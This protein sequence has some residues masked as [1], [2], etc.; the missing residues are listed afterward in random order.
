M[1]SQ[2]PDI[3]VE[4]LQKKNAH[5]PKR[6]EQTEGTKSKRTRDADETFILSTEAS[7]GTDLEKDQRA[8]HSYLAN[9]H[10]LQT[11]PP[12]TNTACQA[13]EK[14]LTD[15]CA[16]LGAE[17]TQLKEKVDYLSFRQ[18]SFRAND[19]MVQEITGL[20][21]YAKFT[22]VFSLVSGFLK[23]HSGL[24]HFQAFL[25]T[26]MRTR[27]N[28]PSSFFEHMFHVSQSTITEVFNSCLDVMYQR[29]SRLVVWPGKEQIQIS[30]PM[31]F[32]AMFDNCTSIIE[33]MEI[34]IEK[35]KKHE[36]WCS[37]VLSMQESGH[38]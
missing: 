31:C 22:T 19:E 33:C 1:P 17:I 13:T 16:A 9:V 34:C 15:E 7:N 35:N 14:A 32:R 29:L 12:C 28:L 36:S 18:K 11:I 30:L 38:G 4:Q 23:A 27:L 8:K 25:M 26:L 6:C 10:S 21:A 5:N 2:F 20:A 37:N 3:W 24:T